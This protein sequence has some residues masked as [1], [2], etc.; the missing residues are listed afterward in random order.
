MT[1]MIKGKDIKF[2][3]LGI[4]VSKAAVAVVGTSVKPLFTVAGGRVLITSIVG[5][6]VTVIQTT[7]NATNVISTPTTG[8][9]VNLCATLDIT[10]DES[11]CLY[12]LT[13]L[14]ADVMVGTNAGAASGLRNGIIV[15]IGVIGMGNAAAACTGSVKWD[16]T[17]IP[18]DDGATVVAA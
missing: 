3:N 2:I 11:G 10:G 13:G 7:A 5:Q 8:T 6:V 16:I 4:S 15:P 18:L 9:A 17:Y 1:T 14:A 12:S